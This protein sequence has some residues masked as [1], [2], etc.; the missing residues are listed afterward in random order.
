MYF[1][2]MLG[3]AE[4]SVAALHVRTSCRRASGYFGDIF[5]VTCQSLIAS[6]DVGKVRIA[7]YGFVIGGR[8]LAHF[9]LSVGC[10]GFHS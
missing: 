1:F 9:F 2:K 3:E 4:S 5:F 7:R 6:E 10:D 8:S